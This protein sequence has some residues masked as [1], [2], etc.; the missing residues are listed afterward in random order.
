MKQNMT[1]GNP[2]S[3]ILRF[4]VPL[5]IG[6]LFQQIYNT[7]DTMIVG[8]YLGENALAAVGSTGTLMF[9]I[10]GLSNGLC[11][12]FTVL[13]SQKFGEG[14]ETDTR[15]SVANGAIL[16][17]IVVAVMTV[18]S[19]VMMPLILHWMN[20]PDNIY[21]DA[22]SYIHVICLGI[23][24]NVAYNYLASCLRAI[25]NSRI[26]LVMLIFSA[27]LNVVLDIALIRGTS[28]GVAGAAWA[29]NIAQAVS[30]VLCLVY[31]IKREPLLC[32]DV[33]MFRLTKACTKHQLSVGIPMALQFG[34]T[35]SGTV[36][37]QAAINLFGST[38]VAA[39][40]AAGKITNLLMQG[41]VSV[42]QTMA[43]YAGQN[44]GAEKM[45]R[46]RKGVCCALIIDIVYAV[47]AGLL[48]YAGLPLFMKFFFN[49]EV[50]MVKMMEYAR[51]YM[52]ISVSFYIPLSVI[53]NFRNA[54]QGCGYGF[55]PM[56]GGVVELVARLVC[57][58]L[59]MKS[60]NYILACFCDPA[61]WLAAGIFTAVSYLF[62]MKKI[63]K[64]T[65]GRKC[66]I[67]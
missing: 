53:F 15:R 56:M 52:G 49:E 46:I 63:D 7:V 59:A 3:I 37:M 47:T 44:F 62:V 2:L 18:L 31:I 58:L 48:A 10:I 14:N 38:A 1:Q 30:A 33:K 25:G 67:T 19:V 45:L 64:T 57:A 65:T 8:Q 32:P 5:F 41:A 34:I 55:L 40:S 23:V 26:P 20:T 6:N 54:M 43:T 13:T 51:T 61:A 11:T 39:Y 36:V 17:A 12:G 42:G 50:D 9:M 28:L 27:L 21:D 35:G 29:T 22:Y 66:D 16:S 24:A 4:T 60:M